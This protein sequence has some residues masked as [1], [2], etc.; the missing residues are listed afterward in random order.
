M[1]IA[2]SSLS[3]SVNNI[4]IIHFI[5][6]LS[7]RTLHFYI[8][9]TIKNMLIL[10]NTVAPL[11]WAYGPSTTCKVIKWAIV[12][13]YSGGLKWLIR[14][15]SMAQMYTYYAVIRIL[16]G[17]KRQWNYADPLY[18]RNS[19][20]ANVEYR[21]SQ[22]HWCRLLSKRLLQTEGWKVISQNMIVESSR[23]RVRSLAIFLVA[24]TKKLVTQWFWST[25]ASLSIGFK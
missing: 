13:R 10:I 24:T 17:N 14:R 19:I 3:F 9:N 22:I 5:T 21:K 16:L 1:F 12:G 8:K 20:S 4:Y 7:K 18:C 2:F 11:L 6:F 15:E 23:F 25:P